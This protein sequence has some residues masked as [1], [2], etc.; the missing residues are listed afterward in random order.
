MIHSA[1]YQSS[2]EN[3]LV[4]QWLG[5][6]ASTA[7]DLVSIPGRELDPTCQE[8]WQKK[9]KSCS[10]S[11]AVKVPFLTLSIELL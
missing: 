8:M 10:I 9:K 11:Y 6:H 2:S 1:L 4:V 5:H 3:S 7:G